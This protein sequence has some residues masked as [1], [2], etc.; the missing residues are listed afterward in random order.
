M[1]YTAEDLNA[2]VTKTL[3]F[4]TGILLL[5]LF[6][7]LFG[8]S[9]VV[10]IYIR[11]MKRTDEKYFIP[12]LA[13]ADI[14]ACL[15]GVILGV[16][17]NFH[18]AYYTL[19]TFCKVGYFLT[20]STTSVSGIII[21][22]IALNRHLMI[23]RPTSPQLT[24]TRK[25]RALIVV[26]I[27]SIVT[28]AP[29]LYFLGERHYP[30][31]YKGELINTTLCT[32]RFTDGTLH[33]LQIGYFAFEI[34]L[35]LLNMIITCVL[36]IP[37]GVKIYR[38]FRKGGLKAKMA[39]QKPDISKA[40]DNAPQTEGPGKLHVEMTGIEESAFS[41]TVSTVLSS[42][43][44]DVYCGRCKSNSKED[45]KRDVRD[46][47][48]NRKKKARNKQARNNFTVMFAT[49]IIFYIL[50]Y[51]PTLVLMMLPGSNPAEF[52]F[53]KS[54][55]MLNFLVF[56]QRAFL[57][58]NIVNAFIYSYFDLSFRKEVKKIL[59]CFICF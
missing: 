5:Y 2:D 20:W 12:I 15:A 42:T 37:V 33:K 52:W 59:C 28:S 36:Y 29:M 23:C 43:E 39:K 27:F 46:T 48:I 13:I 17:S 55:L 41:T 24:I 1:N 26:M 31:M 7:G 53:S 19:D 18:R 16:V 8:N 49:I 6:L 54:P 3:Y 21:L 44:D 25:R 47:S 4:N 9:I 40:Q 32:L 30:F 56:L 51:L 11:R 58:N 35:A 45:S 14:F 22:L 57:L 38:R 10:Y 50:A 34:F